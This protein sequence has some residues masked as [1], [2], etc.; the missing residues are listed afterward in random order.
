MNRIYQVIWSAVA[1]AW[2]VVSELASH[3]T[4]TA[5]VMGDAKAGL[6][7]RSGGQECATVHGWGARVLVIASVI[8]GS[9]I[10]SP[11]LAACTGLNTA[12]VTCSSPP[13]D[14]GNKTSTSTVDTTATL[15]NWQVS[16]G[17]LLL[18]NST[19]SPNLTLNLFA[20]GV[21]ITNT[22]FGAS[23]AAID[24]RAGSNFLLG[25]R[26]SLTIQ[27][28]TIEAGGLGST[29]TAAGLYVNSR[30]GSATLAAT[31]TNVTLSASSV[32]AAVE[33]E[34]TELGSTRLELIGGRISSANTDGF[35]L[36]AR[37]SGGG[38]VTLISAAD[39]ITTTGQRAWGVVASG[40]GQGVVSVSNTAQITTSGLAARGIWASAFRGPVNVDNSG[41]ITTSGT[42]A[43]GLSA[44]SVFSGVSVDNIGNITTNGASAHAILATESGDGAVTVNN[45][46]SIFTMGSG[47]EGIQVSTANGSSS[48]T[49]SGSITTGPAGANGITMT[50]SGTGSG[51]LTNSGNITIN[52]AARALAASSSTGAVTIN[53]QAGVLRITGATAPVVFAQSQGPATINMS[54]G[55]ISIS[56]T[57]SNGNGLEALSSGPGGATVNMT[58]GSITGPGTGI[59]VWNVDTGTGNMSV[60][61]SAGTTINTGST[62][63]FA[64]GGTGTS[65]SVLVDS[66]S[67]ITSTNQ[68]G[69]SATGEGSVP[70]TVKQTGGSIT[71]AGI[72]IL[73]RGGGTIDVTNSATIATNGFEAYG[74]NATTSSPANINVTNAGSISTL[75]DNADGISASSSG[76]ITVANSGAINTAGQTA[77]GIDVFSSGAAVVNVRNSGAIATTGPI[78]S[79]G[80]L[81]NTAGAQIVSDLS[82][83]LSTAGTFSPAI[84]L[85]S[86]RNTEGTGSNLLHYHDGTAS[87]GAGSNVVSL[88]AGGAGTGSGEVRIGANTFV[89]GSRGLAAVQ[90]LMPDDG[91]IV[92]GQGARILGGSSEGVAMLNARATLDTSGDIGAMSDVAIANGSFVNAAERI[93]ITNQATGVLTGVVRLGNGTNALINAGQWNVRR[94]Y[95]SNSDVVRD[96]LAVAVSDFGAGG[97]NAVDNAGTLALLTHDGTATTLDTAGMYL[98]F[99]NPANT[100]ALNSPAQGQLLNLQT[101]NHSGL[102][103]LQANPDAGDVLLIS[104]GATP[105]SDGGGVF[106]ANGGTLAI[107][108]VLNE[109]GAASVSDVLV[110][111][112]TQRGSGPTGVAVNNL[113]GSG[114]VTVGDGIPVVE[115]LNASASAPGAF[116]LAGRAVA[117]PY[118]YL[119]FQ[120]GNP[121]RGGDVG[122]GNWYLR[123]E[124]IPIPPPDPDPDPTPDPPPPDPTPDPIPDPT[125]DPTPDPPVPPAPP[126]PPSPPVPFCVGAECPA[127]LPIIRPE[128]GAYLGNQIAAL[129]LFRHTLHDRLGEVDFSERQR[130]DGR[131]GAVWA[132]VQRGQFD[133]TAGQNQID[134]DSDS[135]LIQIGAELDRWTVSDHRYHIGVMLGWGSAD[136]NAQS[137]WTGYRAKGELEGALIGVY[138]T[139]FQT[140]S[141]ATGLYVDAWLQYGDFRNK[142]RGEFLTQER[143]DSEAWAASVEAGYAFELH[144]GDRTAYYIEPQVQLIHSD[145]SDDVHREVNGTEVRS[146]DA[147]GLVSRLGARA[148]ARPIGTDMHRVQPFVE[149]NWWH[150]E[151]HEAFGF[152]QYV[153]RLERA[154][155]TYEA[156][157]GVQ[158]ELADAWTGWMQLAYRDGDGEYRDVEGLVGVKWGW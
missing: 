102:I 82:G 36:F 92:I 112:S 152:N 153:E 88:W 31:N 17:A 66:Q 14:T 15:S 118:D 65:G 139:W 147:G 85:I 60:A 143:Y 122:D 134:V 63:I 110:L 155:D 100:M 74:I 30:G 106:I 126:V 79:G 98:P 96:T 47:A 43:H 25:G 108:T 40:A 49:N 137:E 130:R 117:G 16:S 1:G 83:N 61:T 129:G 51:I 132:R 42:S 39:S 94:F 103:N 6:S 123:S 113:G 9:A 44:E 138:G 128:V 55:T 109:G 156:K 71:S 140:A 33:V 78:F 95:D 54:G 29:T 7:P 23:N 97:A 131:P 93:D 72:G 87:I 58:G 38:D 101:F 22:T 148:Y 141:Q 90:N 27:N 13:A 62:G 146:V 107:D 104:G 10:A 46:G 111:D 57:N 105:G 80:V 48:V 91:L 2:I 115:V 32:G 21:T 89:D 144:R 119:L 20:D 75:G 8:A 121:A 53:Q 67:S 11:A 34:D 5:S 76:P 70:V 114:A 154:A 133:R 56:G 3:R 50:A 127:P 4:R 135:T 41:A 149:A 69:I 125:P 99:G 86:S 37:G 120:G 64:H 136:T 77:R 158:A 28:S 124:F 157:L 68:G 26:A 81:V 73:A 150:H 52:G 12:T 145:Y 84:E 24:V 151:G 142:V 35:G 18:Q 19:T 116:A 45:S 59:S